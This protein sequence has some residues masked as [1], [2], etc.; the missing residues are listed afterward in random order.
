VD[1][2]AAEEETILQTL[3]ETETFHPYHLH[4]D[5]LE[6]LEHQVQLQILQ[7][8]EAELVKLV[9]LLLLM[10]EGLEETDLLMTTVHLLLHQV[11]QHLAVVAVELHIEE[12]KAQEDLVAEQTHQ[13][14]HLLTLVVAEAVDHLAL[15]EDL[16][17]LEKLL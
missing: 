3:V 17:V 11:E 2:V 10:Q 14:R 7:V 16:V 8:A 15:V 4:K 6:L 9:I 5:T 1:L 13:E 12:H